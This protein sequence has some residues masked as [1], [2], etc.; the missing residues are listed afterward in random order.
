[1]W[2]ERECGSRQY[3]AALLHTVALALSLLPHCGLLA[4]WRRGGTPLS[5]SLKPDLPGIER[6]SSPHLPLPLQPSPYGHTRLFTKLVDDEGYMYVTDCACRQSL[7]M[8]VARLTQVTP[9]SILPQLHVHVATCTC[10]PDKKLY[11]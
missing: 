2:G 4:T 7:N 8:L 9:S 11:I 6:F 1:M 5:V 10:A 3:V